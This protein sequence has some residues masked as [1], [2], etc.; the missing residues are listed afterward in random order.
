[1][2][3]A[4]SSL[5]LKCHSCEVCVRGN[6]NSALLFSASRRNQGFDRRHCRLALSKAASRGIQCLGMPQTRKRSP[7]QTLSAPERLFKA[8]FGREMTRAERKRF[9]WEKPLS[10]KQ[11][12]ERERRESYD[13]L[14]QT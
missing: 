5:K 8:A 7:R 2:Q 1:M 6:W 4:R 9:I 3:S 11:L 12:R 14:R 13:F 10:L